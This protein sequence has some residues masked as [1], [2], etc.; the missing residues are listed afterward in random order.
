MFLYNV[1]ARTI[2]DRVSQNLS[3][4]AS[5]SPFTS[6]FGF[7]FV[8]VESMYYITI[9]VPKLGRVVV[10]LRAT[11]AII[12]SVRNFNAILKW[13]STSHLVF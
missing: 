8:S 2:G 3:F 12:H 7:G 13:R 5:L 1:L 11:V 10:C 9:E 4:S 6:N